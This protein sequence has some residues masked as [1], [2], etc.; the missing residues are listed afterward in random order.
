M[1]LRRPTASLIEEACERIREAVMQ[2]KLPPGTPLS[3]R[4]LAEQL[5]VST[6]PITQALHRLDAEGLVECRPRAGTRVK[7]ATTEEIRGNYVLREALET[8]SARLFAES[9]D[10]VSRRRLIRAAIRLDAAYASLAD[11]RVSGPQRHGRVERIHIAFHMSIAE[12]TG[13]PLLIQ[14]IERSRVLLFNWLYTQSGEFT[15][16]PERWHRDLAHALVN[17]S[18]QHA[19]EAMRR[20]VRFRQQEVIARFQALAESRSGPQRMVRGPQ[21]R[22]AA[23]GGPSLL[24]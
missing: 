23:S 3:R 15:P 1:S 20:H 2:G 13:V 22:T 6:A 19:S 5:Q 10:A 9:A 24:F 17:G 16:L 8:H 4:R 21:R 11:A 18:P 7:I 14:E 12:A